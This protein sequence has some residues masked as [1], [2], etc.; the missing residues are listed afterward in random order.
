MMSNGSRTS[1]EAPLK[2]WSYD[3]HNLFLEKSESW[4]GAIW[5]VY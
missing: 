2:I 5:V 4:S 3:G 1:L